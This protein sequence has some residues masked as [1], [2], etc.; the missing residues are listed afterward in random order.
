MMVHFLPHVDHAPDALLSNDVGL[1]QGRERQGA[2][3]H[4]GP[5]GDDVVDRDGKN[6]LG[7]DAGAEQ[8]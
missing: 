1:A 2:P 5:L 7:A 8:S 3:L 6:L 4:I